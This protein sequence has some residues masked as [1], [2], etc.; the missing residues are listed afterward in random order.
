MPKYL[1]EVPADPFDRKPMR[2]KFT[3]QGL[4]IYSVYENKVDDGGVFWDKD[5][6][7]RR[8][9]VGI[10]LLHVNHRKLKWLEENPVSP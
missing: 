4:L 6:K 1:P 5:K 9:D 7:P 8:P 3:E 2:Y 10:E